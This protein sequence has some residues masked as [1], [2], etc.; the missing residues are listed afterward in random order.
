MTERSLSSTHDPAFE[1]VPRT[2]IDVEADLEALRDMVRGSSPLMN[3]AWAVDL[4]EFEAR[5][6]QILALL[7]KEMR[8]ARR[9]AREEQRILSDA[10]EEARRTLENARVES[11]KTVEAARSE[12][13]RLVESSTIKRMATEQA[14]E[15][16][17]RSEES[18][19]QIREGGFEYA[20][21]VISS[22][23]DSLQKLLENV[24]SD[25]ESQLPEPTSSP[26]EGE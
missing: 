19:R 14:E 11:E 3:R 25:R 10:K 9:I 8:R 13:E 4:D 15:I 12:A 26:A 24:R 21:G 2:E 23:E 1:G 17:A 22:V 20:R 16:I 6:D 5:M 7:P 18:A